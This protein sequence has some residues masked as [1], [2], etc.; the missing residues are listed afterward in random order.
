MSNLRYKR[1]RPAQF[2]IYYDVCDRHGRRKMEEMLEAI[3]KQKSDP[4]YFFE[5]CEY[6]RR[7]PEEVATIFGWV[8]G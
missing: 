2:A 7:P 5:F 1:V 6:T 8:R 4:L 3:G